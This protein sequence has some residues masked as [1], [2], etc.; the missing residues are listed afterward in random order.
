MDLELRFLIVCKSIKHHLSFRWNRV[1][2]SLNSKILIVIR[3]VKAF[4]LKVNREFAR[5]LC[6]TWHGHLSMS[7]FLSQYPRPL[8]L[9]HH[10]LPPSIL[11]EDRRRTSLQCGLTGNDGLWTYSSIL[12]G[13]SLPSH[14]NMEKHDS[15]GHFHKFQFLLSMLSSF[16]SQCLFYAQTL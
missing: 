3:T 2:N 6:L 15:C 12:T 10:R 1:K 16:F 8:K 14:R 11:L 13:V 7:T 9:N 5:V 4:I